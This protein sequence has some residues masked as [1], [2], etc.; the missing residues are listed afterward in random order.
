MVSGVQTCALP[1][2]NF[3]LDFI[4][5]SDNVITS[6]KDEIHNELER[7]H[8]E[9][10]ELKS[11]LRHVSSEYSDFKKT[12]CYNSCPR[13]CNALRKQREMPSRELER[14]LIFELFSKDFPNLL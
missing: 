5:A 9:N 11:K 4:A 1:I 10:L 12:Y 14:E 7:V 3:I 6:F 8:N 13:L 2:L